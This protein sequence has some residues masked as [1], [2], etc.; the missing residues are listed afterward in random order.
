MSDHFIFIIKK[1]YMINNNVKILEKNGLEKGF[2]SENGLGVK[3]F[4]VQCWFK[5]SQPGSLFQN[6]DSI[7]DSYFLVEITKDGKIQF[8]TKTNEAIQSIQS[9]KGIVNSKEWVHL[10]ALKQGGE[11]CLLINGKQIKSSQSNQMVLLE[12][13]VSGIRVGRRFNKGKEEFFGGEIG[14]VLVWDSALSSS[15]IRTNYRRPVA[16]NAD[17]LVIQIPF[18]IADDLLEGNVENDHNQPVIDLQITEL[19]IYNDSPNDFHLSK[20]DIEDTWPNTILAKSKT[21]V[22]FKSCLPEYHNSAKY[23]SEGEHS[24]E[25]FLNIEVNKTTPNY[26]SFVKAE[27]SDDLEKQ[28]RVDKNDDIR[29]EVALRISENL[30]IVNAKNL[31]KFLNVV[32]PELGKE[33]VVTSMNYDETTG[34]ATSTG[35]QIVRYNQATQI[36]NRR[37]QKEPLAI[38]NCKSTEDVQL[39]YKT[40]I[41]NNLPIKVRSGGHDHEGECTGT[42]VILIDLIGLDGLEIKEWN[43]ESDTINVAAIGPGRRFNKLTP[44]LAKADRMIPHG[45]CATVAIPGFTMGGGWG[46]WTRSKG[47]CCEHL[48]GAEI[49]LGDGSKEIIA[50]ERISRWWDGEEVVIEKNKPGLLWALKGG[51]GMSYGI[52]T[53]LYIKT[54]EL[55]RSLVK[56]ELEWNTYNDAQV[57]QGKIP[58]LQILKRW[59]EIIDADN[60]G[61]LTGTNLKING[62]PLEIIGYKDQAESIPIYEDLNTD[63]VVHNC[64]MYGYWEGNEGHDET[65]DRLE[66]FVKHQFTDFG[67]EPCIKKIDGIGGLG[68]DYIPELGNWDRESFSNVKLKELANGEESLPYPPDLDDPAPHKITSRLVNS[69]GLGDEGHKALLTSL[70]SPLILEE[71][72]VDGLF[73]YVTLGA[74]VGDFYNTIGR[75]DDSAFPYKDKK[76]TIQYQTW[77]NLELEEKEQ[78]Q[79]NDVYNRKNRALDWIEVSRDFKIEN[80]SGAFISFKDN[81]I[82]TKTYFAQNYERL[83]WVKAMYSKDPENHLRS[84]KTII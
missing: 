3:E 78:L 61:D 46:P 37:I 23:I 8:T 26:K 25:T 56:F 19:T 81:S 75:V 40:A 11:L 64:V 7:A 34:K 13:M 33:N 63:T 60:T 48:I 66:A 70:T 79:D 14:G 38:I 58:T 41:E 20:E 10:T 15:E 53:K 29:L 36:F 69:S 83:K 32:I 39:A 22:I 77:W 62:K 27:I 28:I 6:Y 2:Q 51:G 68:S 9:V 16:G 43:T 4:T 80:T 45:T 31:N 76:Y 42:N 54:F 65:K 1:K 72:R 44:E 47:M 57:L 50:S 74:I 17:G 82:P 5:T 24:I 18:K 35:E 21:C 59:E 30:V 84:R 49:I 55:P 67:L 71:N 12:D 52:V 73:T